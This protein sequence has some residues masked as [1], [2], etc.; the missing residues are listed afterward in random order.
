MK[1]TSSA[2]RNHDDASRSSPGLDSADVERAWTAALD[3]W[4]VRL[5]SPELWPGKGEA[6]GSFAW[7]GFPPRVHIDPIMV[8]E[9]AIGAELETVF[10]HEIGHHVLAPATRIDSLKIRH[11]MARA[12]A[13]TGIGD[14]DTKAAELANLWSDLLVNTRIHSLQ[15]ARLGADRRF[16]QEPAAAEPGIVRIWRALRHDGGSPLMWVYL[17]ASEILWRLP[18][19]SLCSAEP[20]QVAVKAA[21]AMP[22]PANSPAVGLDR[23]ELR[24]REFK[25]AQASVAQLSQALLAAAVAHPHM[26]A[27]SIAT[28]ARVFAHDPVGGALPFGLIASPY[29][30]ANGGRK[31]GGGRQ[32]PR[33]EGEPPALGGP[34]PLGGSGCSDVS[35][36]P[37][38]AEIGRVLADRR[39]WEAPELPD[40]VAGNTP[41]AV[42]TASDAVGQGLGLAQTVGLYPTVNSDV[43]AVAWYRAQA[44]AHVR[45][46]STRSHARTAHELP[47]PLEQWETGEDLADLDWAGTLQASPVVVPGLTTKR[48]SRLED[49]PEP[50]KASIALDLYIDS[51]GSMPSP[52]TGSPAVLAG[53][54]LCLSILKGGGTVRVTSFSGPGQVAGQSN[55]SGK[56]ET[57]LAGLLHYFGGSTSFP[58]DRYGERYRGLRAPTAMD[59]RHV[60]ALSDDGLSSMFGAGNEQ[61]SDVAEQVRRVLTTGTLILLDRRK[62]VAEPAER[63]GYHVIYLESMDDAP[64]ACAALAEVLRG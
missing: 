32:G 62:T 16:A 34:D 37:T 9:L 57:V 11:Q 61:Y 52:R 27:A 4:G 55:F 41:I 13:A 12:L 53:A 31:R 59:A 1:R 5:R 42:G 17:R 64:A 15:S 60:V 56:S 29:L 46:W 8:A 14:L 35:E 63:A 30:S 39:M 28:L 50:G 10:A 19:D 6:I 48:R 44:A 23:A 20:P 38:G 45:P 58:L 26:D 36:A 47:G 3:L 2:D 22:G 18:S 25:D 43:V 49:E 51:S 40:A 33:G 7:F 21:P 24:R 54:I